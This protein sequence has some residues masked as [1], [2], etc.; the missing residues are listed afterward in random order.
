MYFA[1][2][3]FERQHERD[4]I[5]QVTCECTTCLTC[6]CRAGGGVLVRAENYYDKLAPYITPPSST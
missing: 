3:N 1:E 4:H 5:M 6:A 2:Q